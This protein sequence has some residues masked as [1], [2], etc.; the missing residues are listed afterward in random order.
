[1][2]VWFVPLLWA[3]GGQVAR[4]GLTFGARRLLAGNAFRIASAHGLRTSS[5]RIALAAGRG[6]LKGG[7]HAGRGLFSATAKTTGHLWRNKGRYMFGT[8]AAAGADVYLTGGKNVMGVGGWLAEKWGGIVN[9]GLDMLPNETLLPILKND[10]Q[11]IAQKHKGLPLMGLLEQQAG[12]L[13]LGMA[14]LLTKQVA[15]GNVSG[16]IGT[17]GMGLAVHAYANNYIQDAIKKYAPDSIFAKHADIT[18]LAGLAVVGTSF[19]TANF[20]NLALT[21]AIAGGA[22]A[23]AT[24]KITTSDVAST[25]NR[26]LNMIGA[27]PV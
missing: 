12:T 7:I 10:F 21:A 8:A 17:V 24:G 26:G 4:M 5:S 20:M 23:F 22:Y 25:L 14:A 15:T 18:A 9:G 2:P 6:Y 11:K 13:T 1:M 3:A 27:A 19:A 16:A